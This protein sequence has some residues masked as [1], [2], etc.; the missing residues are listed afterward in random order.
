MK[1]DIDSITA[2][3]RGEDSVINY[4]LP[5]TKRDADNLEKRKNGADTL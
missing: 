4:A 5:A 1:P 2:A 3:A